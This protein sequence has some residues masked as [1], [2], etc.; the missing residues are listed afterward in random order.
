MPSVS[1][2]ATDPDRKW[3]TL[4]TPHFAIHSHDDGVDFA[5]AVG[6]YCE[7]A[8]RE[9]GALFEWYPKERV[10]VVVVDDFD[11]AN[12]FAGVIPY[13]AMTI[14]AHP[15]SPES[16]LGHYVD[17]VRLLV[18]HEYTHIV[19]LDVSGGIPTWVD[20]IFGRIWKPNNALPRWVTEGIAVYIES[21]LTG[22]GRVGSPLSETYFRTSALAGRLPEL[23]DLTGYPLEMPRGSSWYIYGGAIFDHIDRAVGPDAIRRFAAEYG[24]H[25]IPFGLNTLAK[26]ATGKTFVQWFAE[27]REGIAA[28]AEATRNVRVEV[29][30]KLVR[31]AREIIDAPVFTPDGKWLL[32]V[33][34]DGYEAA[35]IVRRRADAPHATDAIGAIDAQDVE[36][37][38]RCEGGCGRIRPS[39]DGERLFLTSG[40]HHKVSMFYNH[41][42]E[43]PLQAGLGRRTPRVLTDTRRTYDPEP[44]ADGRGLWAARTRWGVGELVRVDVSTGEVLEHLPVPAALTSKDSWPRFDDPQVSPDGTS[45]WVSLHTR[46][47]RNL[48]RV[49]L[50]TREF[51]R[52]TGGGSMEQDPHLS[53]DGR[54]L[55]YASDRSGVQDVYVLEL[56][57]GVHR[58]L[59]QTLTSATMPTLSPDGS[60]LIYRRWSVAGGELRALPFREGE[61][62][63]VDPF[64]PVVKPP[65]QHAA[66]PTV[67]PVTPI[68]THDYHALPTMLPRSWFPSYT[69]DSTGLSTLGLAF[70]STDASGRF[71][72]VLSVDWN[73][74]R[75]DWGAF[76]SFGWRGGFPDLTLQLGRYTWDRS[77]RVGDL[78]EP[79]I[80]EVVYANASVSLPVPDV[81]AGLSW[82]IGFSGD[83]VRGASFGRLLQ[84]PDQNMPFI[85]REGFGTSANLFFGVFDSRQ[86]SLDVSPS[87]GLSASFNLSLRDPAIGSQASVMTFSFVSRAFLD[88]PGPEGH[89]LA[90]R[91]GGGLSG[92]EPGYRSV[93]SLG[94][95]PKQE[96]LTDLLNQTAAGSVWLR[97]FPEGHLSGTRFGL[98]T[99]EWRFPLL[100]AR[101]GIET[102]PVFIED[103]SVAVFSDIGT[104]SYEADLTENIRAGFGVEVRFRLELFYG[105]LNDFR[106]GYARGFGE[107]GID[108]FYVLMAPSP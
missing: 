73:L 4:T 12:G 26:K 50:A 95:V 86:H 33:E 78:E 1:H 67:D 108:Q 5:R 25:P 83:L 69:A 59:T 94:G 10:H 55:F 90:F 3:F 13:P 76:T 34:S 64:A 6:E 96:L 35:R 72:L 101:A 81:F 52:L 98:V 36:V 30:G 92:G 106:I 49:D 38:L 19:H 53:S 18:F 39:R 89:V 48:Y 82:G 97:G 14:W 21:K 99:T 56:E 62:V 42:A 60:T 2:A 16:E 9:V 32:W 44:T 45:L 40:R 58:R 74:V 77:S 43:V 7:E 80:E 68:E 29:P 23:S 8:Y 103:L 102:L 51:H 88:L 104:A 22:R 28:R 63:V 11:A 84:T 91:L 17:W 87:E 93:F 41:L 47:E 75:E 54:L 57:T 79:Y 27:V 37:V 61:G 71:G 66:T 100:R 105:I 85:P 107:F 24:S 31:S 15:P 70:E 20:A 65:H 46:G